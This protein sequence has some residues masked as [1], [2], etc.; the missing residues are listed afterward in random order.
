MNFFFHFS[1]LRLRGIIIAPPIMVQ[2]KNFSLKSYYLC[3][4]NT[5]IVQNSKL[6]PKKF[7]FLCT[8][9]LRGWTRKV[10]QQKWLW[11]ARIKT[12][13]TF[14]W[15]L[16]KNL[17]SGK[18][19]SAY[20]SAAALCGSMGAPSE[21]KKNNSIN[22]VYWGAHSLCRSWYIWVLTNS[23]ADPDPDPSDAYVF[24]LLDPDP[25]ARGMEQIWIL[26]SSCKN[27]KKNLDSYCFMTLFDFLSLKNFVNVPLKSNKQK[28]FFKISFL[29]ASW[30]SM[31]KMAG[32]GSRIR[33]Q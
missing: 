8:V 4:T 19:T 13:K 1:F 31:M 18:L 9:P 29:L 5:E 15:I 24:R 23:V 25:L 7:S 10:L 14:V 32:S 6:K 3:I 17:A 28:N 22:I 2:S 21:I 11:I 12:L 20:A 27:S 16:S 26:Q 30:R 33:I